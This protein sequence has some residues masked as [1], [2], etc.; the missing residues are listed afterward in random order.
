LPG[1]QIS[2]DFGKTWT[3]SPLSPSKPLFPEPSKHLGP[4]KMPVSTSDR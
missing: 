4:V 1:F 2:R 3:P